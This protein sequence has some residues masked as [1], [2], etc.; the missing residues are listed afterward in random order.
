MK[1]YS[2]IY[3]KTDEAKKY[4]YDDYEISEIGTEAYCFGFSFYSKNYIALFIIYRYMPGVGGVDRKDY[5]FITYD[6]DGNQIDDKFIG[7][8]GYDSNMGVNELLS[9]NSVLYFD[10]NHN[11]KVVTTNSQDQ[12]IETD[13]P[14]MQIESSSVTDS[15]NYVISKNGKIEKYEK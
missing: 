4:I 13:E 2:E 6:Y 11:I 12:L 3:I 14:D 5:Q 15:T 10:E 9:D 8:S 7:G 1:E